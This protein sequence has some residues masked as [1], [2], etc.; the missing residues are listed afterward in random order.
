MP[1]L[2]LKNICKKYDEESYAVKNVNLEVDDKDFVILVGPSGCGKS[3]TLRM[4]AGLEEISEGEMW[5]DGQFANYLTHKERDL[6]MVFQ[7]YA[8]YP[9]MSVYDNIAFSL[10]VR[11]VSKNTIKEKVNEVAEIL[12]LQQLLKRMPKELSG[13][14]KQRVAIAS[15][16]IRN[17]KILLMDEP[18]SNL[19]AKLRNHMRVEMSKLHKKL[20]NTII[21][22]THDQTE[23]MTLGTKI[24]VLKDGEVHQIDT[25]EA[26]Y[27][28][29]VNKFVAGFI[30]LPSMNFI[31][32][33]LKNENQ[34]MYFNLGNEKV[35]L[36]KSKSDLL[37]KKGYEN[38]NVIIGI[39]PEHITNNID[40][41]ER[42][43][44]Y[45]SSPISV[46]VDLSEML[47]DKTNIY[48]KI[49]DNDLT[50]IFK[51]NCNLG[52]GDKAEVLIYTKNICI[53][54]EKSEKNILHEEVKG[55]LCDE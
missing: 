38:K 31:K 53:F 21:Y 18:L 16:I 11:K 52:I 6:S 50:A 1:K 4:I 19:D 23:A 29:P 49:G 15:A 35:Y 17:P 32:C 8:L 20:N 24:V 42:D 2:L 39:R 7:N 40:M 5:L 28:N 36:P 46:K 55:G 14:Q 10:K 30:G 37:I 51:D 13:G 25:P 22:V 9:T 27:D 54:D 26:L 41:T 12:G 34:L 43:K 47:G 44:E 48:F 33:Q 3:T 45:I